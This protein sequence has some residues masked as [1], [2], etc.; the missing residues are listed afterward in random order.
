MNSTA[1]SGALPRPEAGAS[2][3]SRARACV[4]AIAPYVPGRGS[5]SADVVKL[6]SNENPLGPG[7]RAL[8][9]LTRPFEFGRYPDGG[10][11]EARDAI[12]RLHRLGE[13]QV[14]LGNG[15]NDVLDLVARCFV[16][17]GDEVIYSQHAF[18]VYPLVTQAAGGVGVEV[19][20]SDYAHDLDAMLAHISPQT[21]VIM[22]A[23]PNNPTG[24]WHGGATVHRFI[25]QVP[26]DVVVVLD[27]AY[28]GYP[29]ADLVADGTQWLGEYPNLVVTRSF[30][31]IHGLAALRV[32]Y[33]VSSVEVADL[34]NRVRQPFNVNTLGLAAAAAALTD[35]AHVAASRQLNDAGLAQLQ[36]AFTEMGL[37]FIDSVG[38]FLCFEPGRPGREVFTALMQRGVFVRPVDNYGLPGHLRVSIGTEAENQAFLAALEAV[39]A[40]SAATG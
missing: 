36:S 9:V 31:K 12:A 14:T 27:E 30:S 1:Q 3:V 16:G 15:S 25:E 24:T 13:D 20:A 8:E 6:A 7:A 10:G 22:V 17:P 38:N 34:L 2:V 4:R 23:N 18:A 19:P 28:A 32:G 29:A 11:V 33:A 37:P 40:N 26:T 5:A 35:E 39:L 21:R